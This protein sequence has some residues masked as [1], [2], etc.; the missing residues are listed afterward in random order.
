MANNS[1][2]RKLKIGELTKFN[3]SGFWFEAGERTF[4]P[5]VSHSMSHTLMPIFDGFVIFFIIV[6][7]VVHFIRSLHSMSSRLSDGVSE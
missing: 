4:R 7:V 1:L 6:F 5:V 2:Y 3:K